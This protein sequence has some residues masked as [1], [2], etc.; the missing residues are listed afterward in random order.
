MYDMYDLILK[1][2]RIVD[3]TGAPW[4]RGDV[5]VKDGRIAKIGCITDAGHVSGQAL[6]NS[7]D[8]DAWHVSGQTLRNSGDADAGHVSGQASEAG[9]AGSSGPSSAQCAAAAEVVDCEDLYLAPGFIDIHSHSDE[10]IAKYPRNESRILQGVTT[11]LTGNCGLSTVPVSADPEKAELLSSYVA[12]TDTSVTSVAEL[13]EH[14]E[15]DVKPSTNIALGVG[16][17]SLRIAA[18]GFDDRVP[19]KSEMDKMKGLLRESLEEGAFYMS[20]GLI[21]PPGIFAATD[22]ITELAKILPEY[23]AF[24]ATHMRNEGDRLI[25]AV[26]E[27]ITIAEKSGA[28]LEISHHKALRRANWGKVRESTAIIEEARNRGIDVRCDQY[29]YTATATTLDSNVPNWAFEGGV[30]KML[31]RLRDPETRQRLVDESNEN[32]KGR[33]QDISVAYA[34]SDDLRWTQGLDMVTIADKMGT[35]PASACFDILLGTDDKA[36]EVDRAICED[37]VQ[38]VMQKPYVMIG[39]DGNALSLEGGTVPHPRSFGTFVRVLC[40][41]ARDLKL[42]SLEEGVRKMTSMPAARMGLQDRG[43]IKEGF[44]AD[45]VLFDYYALKD[46]PTYK[47]PIAVC[48]GIRRVYVNGTLTAK[49]GQHTGARAGKVLRRGKD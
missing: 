37:D 32:H 5:A 8:A 7:G 44:A 18:M 28:P 35:D 34:E 2:C 3:G 23:G 21:Y 13:A 36:G 49:D 25:K 31:A 41:Y 12:G 11:E 24:Y 17:G 9:A 30:K 27:A 22:E 19:E 40:R 47:D 42:F 15:K 38:F 33:W 1:N 48:E 26:V 4:Y 39:S 14:L 10:T 46:T 43:L 20:T 45:M 16:H 6:R 29:P